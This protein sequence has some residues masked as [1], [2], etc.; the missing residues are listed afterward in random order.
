MLLYI[1]LFVNVL[2][3]SLY[4]YMYTCL[5]WHIYVYIHFPLS[6]LHILL[7]LFRGWI[8][9]QQHNRPL[10]V[11]SLT[12]VYS[13]DSFF[14]IRLNSLSPQQLLYRLWHR[15]PS[16][17]LNYQAFHS[18]MEPRISLCIRIEERSPIIHTVQEWII[19]LI[20]KRYNS[21][22]PY[23]LSHHPGIS[24]RTAKD[25]WKNQGYMK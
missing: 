1:A 4:I 25:E 14:K 5:H 8:S 24:Y 21:L 3:L 9:H 20:L 17:P 18:W 10:F 15:P 23:L 19:A 12:Q 13:V 6:P 16:H 7:Y 2:S 22:H 11:I